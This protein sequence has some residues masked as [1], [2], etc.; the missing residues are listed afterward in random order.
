M[1]EAGEGQ[2]T[3]GAAHDPEDMDVDDA[4]PIGSAIPISKLGSDA[5]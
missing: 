4:A 2:A 1:G 5:A 3:N